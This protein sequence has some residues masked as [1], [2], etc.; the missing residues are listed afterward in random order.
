MLHTC[1]MFSISE[2][3]VNFFNTV[4]GI[5]LGDVTNHTPIRWITALGARVL[6]EQQ[7]LVWC[8][9][10]SFPLHNITQKQLLYIIT[11]NIQMW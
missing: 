2:I 9:H 1:D 3:T 5:S 10:R 6:F 11:K 4:D 7:S 8:I